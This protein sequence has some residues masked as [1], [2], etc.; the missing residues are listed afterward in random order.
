MSQR[1]LVPADENMLLKL[2]HENNVQEAAKFL[3]W[4]EKPI[5]HKG[6]EVARSSEISLRVTSCP[7]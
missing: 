1:P 3:P 4:P 7:L 5:N 2:G 6:H